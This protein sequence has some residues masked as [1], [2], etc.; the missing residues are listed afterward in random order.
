MLHDVIIIGAGPVGLVAS[1]LLSKY[2]VSHLLVEQ[3][4]QPAEHPQAHFINSRTMEILRELDG[5]DEQVRINSTPLAHWQRFV[6]CTNLVDL[7]PYGRPEKEPTGSLL[8]MVDHFPAGPDHTISPVWAA[9]LPQHDFVD[10][11]RERCQKSKSC[12]MLD[13]QTAAVEEHAD[14]VDVLLTHIETGDQ[15][16]ESARFVICAYGAHSET[17]NQLGIELNSNGGTLQ[18]LINIHFFSRQL[19][20]VLCER[21]PAMLYFIYSTS[22]IGILVNHSLERGEFVFQIPYFPPYQR[23]EE[24][25]ARKCKELIKQLAG[26]DLEVGINNARAWRM[27]TWSAERFRSEAGRCFLVGDAAH[28]FP[29]SGGFGMNT[30]IEDVHNLA[31]KLALALNDIGRSPDKSGI[32]LLGTFEAERMPVA[33]LIRRVSVDNFK[34]STRISSAIGLDW[35]L[36]KLAHWAIGIVPVPEGLKRVT[37]NTAMRFGLAQ[38][39]LLESENIVSKLRRKRLVQIFDNS[40]DTLQL[41]FPR[42]E[43][44]TVY[45]SEWA[46]GNVRSDPYKTKSHAYQP[47]LIAGGRIPH[48]WLRRNSRRTK[49]ELSSLDLPTALLDKRSQPCF[50]Y[51]AGGPSPP[52]RQD[53]DTTLQNKFFPIKT[54]RIGSEGSRKRNADYVFKDSRPDFLPENFAAIVR[55]DGYIGWL[56]V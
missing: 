30:G 4:R 25:T 2:R 36:A 7:P 22:G 20:G 49:E 18:H 45:T 19:A 35:Q 11:L 29:P 6:Y 28:Q 1:L 13:G 38:V 31:W 21:L 53:L 50:L 3:R 42:L 26:D 32:G 17:R 39:E 44:G 24:F 23:P 43:L 52:L 40:T 48:F 55:P 33:D 9:H 47:Q 27:G 34:K 12:M 8:G 5:L 51:L 56:S 15:Q 41:L 37:F 16:H 14:R 10:L 46:A 54:V